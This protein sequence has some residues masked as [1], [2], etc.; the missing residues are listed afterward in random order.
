MS[1]FHKGALAVL[2]KVLAM[3]LQD[4]ASA[5]SVLLD[6]HTGCHGL[7][8]FMGL[9]VSD[10]LFDEEQGVIT[11]RREFPHETVVMPFSSVAAVVVKVLQA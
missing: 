11:L 3:H 7:Y 6:I 2:R 8:G 4:G 1:G 10:V 9:P 5:S